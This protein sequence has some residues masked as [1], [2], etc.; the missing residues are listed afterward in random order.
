MGGVLRQEKIPEG[1]SEKPPQSETLL[2]ECLEA[3][4]IS[5]EN[6]DPTDTPVYIPTTQT[7]NREVSE[8]QAKPTAV[9]TKPIGSGGGYAKRRRKNSKVPTG[10]SLSG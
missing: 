1:W 6:N 8:S 5:K 7:N 4:N 3:E 2:Q 10:V 9:K